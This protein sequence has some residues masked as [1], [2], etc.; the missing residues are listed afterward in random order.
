[1]HRMMTVDTGATVLLTHCAA[2][3]PGPPVGGVRL[4]NAS[5]LLRHAVL[6]A[7]MFVVHMIAA[8]PSIRC[9][10]L[11]KCALP[12]SRVQ[13]T[14]YQWLQSTNALKSKRYNKSTSRKGACLPMTDEQTAASRLV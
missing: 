4:R 9:G 11:M 1:M 6:V 2:G 5:I 14:F 12:T 3:L 7:T 8:R 10:R 13:R